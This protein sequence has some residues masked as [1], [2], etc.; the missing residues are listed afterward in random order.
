MH[1]PVNKLSQT[2][3]IKR[4]IKGHTDP[5]TGNWV[6]GGEFAIA[7]ITNANIQPK[8]GRERAGQSG[9]RYESDYK[10]FAGSDDITYESGY[11][12]SGILENDIAVDADGQKYS[13]VFPGLWPGHHYELDLKKG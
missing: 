4:N 6:E 9:T 5:D 11:E 7:T 1:L 13:V 12:G 10:L 2:V 3:T 8:S